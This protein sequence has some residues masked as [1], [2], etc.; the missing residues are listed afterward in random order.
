MGVGTGTQHW[1][2]QHFIFPLAL[3]GG[4]KGRIPAIPFDAQ[5]HG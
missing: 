4:V 5:A 1:S 3:S 2:R